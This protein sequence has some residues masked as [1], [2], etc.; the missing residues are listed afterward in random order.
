MDILV[1]YTTDSIHISVWDIILKLIPHYITIYA[2]QI[3]S[4]IKYV[5]NNINVKY[6]VNNKIIIN[7]NCHY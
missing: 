4:L 1:F 3:I 5:D 2:I 6:V 7:T